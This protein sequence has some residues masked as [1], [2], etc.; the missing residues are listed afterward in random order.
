MPLQIQTFTCK[1]SAV[2]FK[3]TINIVNLCAHQVDNIKGYHAILLI[4]NLILTFS[5]LLLQQP[6][7][8]LSISSCLFKLNSDIYSQKMSVVRKC[9]EL[10]ICKC[11]MHQTM[12]WENTKQPQSAR[13]FFHLYMK[14][15]CLL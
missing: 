15:I 10:Y 8:I 5:P 2:H 14:Q 7:Q 6:F 3:T 13:L 4:L 1:H 9:D 11:F 12:L